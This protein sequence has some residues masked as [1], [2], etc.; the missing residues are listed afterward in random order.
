MMKIF[1]VQNQV[2][3]KLIVASFL[4]FQIIFDWKFYKYELVLDFQ[5]PCPKLKNDVY[6]IR[7]VWNID[8]LFDF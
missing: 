4:Q 6:E 2:T 8:I 5:K 1:P 7:D 3:L